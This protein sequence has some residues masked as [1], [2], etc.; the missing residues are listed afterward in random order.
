M[1]FKNKIDQKMQTKL[2]SF[3][4]KKFLVK[5]KKNLLTGH[6][7]QADRYFLQNKLNYMADSITGPFGGHASNG[8]IYSLICSGIIGFIAF[9]TLNILVFFKY[10]K[11]VFNEKK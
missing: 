8:Y 5:D 9:F 1:F 3:N 4:L 7:P 10:I 11:L 6:G 2:V